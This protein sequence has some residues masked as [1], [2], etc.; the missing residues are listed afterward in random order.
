ML[1]VRSFIITVFF[2]SSVAWSNENKEIKISP[3]TQEALKKLKL[4]GVKINLDEWSVDVDAEVCLHDGLLELILCVDNT[5]EHESI[6]STKAR[7]LHIHTALL[8]MGSKPGTP[9]MKKVQIKGEHQWVSVEPSGDD[10]VLSVVLPSKDGSVKEYPINKFVSSATAENQEQGYGEMKKFPDKFIFSGSHLIATANG[11]KKYLCEDSGN[12]IS[13]STFGDEMV[14]L[15]EVT[16]HDNN[17]L[18]WKVN[19]QLLPK[20]GDK[21]IIRLKSKNIRK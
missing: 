19:P 3:Q 8:L 9:A 2:A 4:P 7:A 1:S 15:S 20:I 6:F 17:K 16:G 12:V 21:V 5:K 11:Q 18:G 10:I 13:V 14:C